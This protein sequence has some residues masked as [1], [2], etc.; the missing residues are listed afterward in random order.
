MFLH[1]CRCTLA[2]ILTRLYL[3]LLGTRR[4]VQSPRRHP[5]RRYAVRLTG[6][7]SAPWLQRSVS[8]RSSW[9]HS[10]LTKETGGQFRVTN[11]SLETES[12]IFDWS[13]SHPDS[14]QWAAFY[15]DC[16]HEVMEVE[17][18]HRVTLTYNLYVVENMGGVVQTHPTADAKYSPLLESAKKLLEDPSFMKN[19]KKDT[20]NA[21]PRLND[22]QGGDLASTALTNTPTITKLLRNSC[23]LL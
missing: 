9:V 18:G 8:L 7:V 16:E 21:N 2:Q 4:E 15:S 5:A 17:E 14:I 13:K 12:T 19:G 1:T 3:D 10:N 23:H 11:K 20:S 6:R 22:K